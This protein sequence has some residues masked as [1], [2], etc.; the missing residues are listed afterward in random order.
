MQLDFQNTATAFAHRSDA[1]LQRALWMF[2]LIA[3]PA[4]VNAGEKLV[5]FGLRM[6]LPLKP[7]V[8]ATL[9]RQFAGGETVEECIPRIEELWRHKVATILDY[10]VE[11]QSTRADFDTTVQEIRKTIDLAHRHPAIPFSVFKMSGLT[12]PHVLERQGSPAEFEALRQ[13]VLDI[14]QHAHN[15]QVPVFIDAEESWVQETIDGLAEEMMQRFNRERPLVFT[16]LQFY[17]KDRLKYL[18]QLIQKSYAGNFWLGIKLVRGAYLEKESARARQLH[19]PNPLQNSKEE[20]DA[21]FNHALDVCLQHLERIHICA[22]THNEESTL[23]LVQK[24]QQAGLAPD[25]PRIWFSQLLG[26]SD[27]ISFNLAAAGYNVAKYMPYAPVESLIPYLV[28]RARENTSVQ[29]Q[30]GRE[31]RLLRQELRRRRQVRR[32]PAN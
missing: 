7:L 14:C 25:D 23:Y 16:T 18:E 22:G 24:M 27:H 6:R 2:R 12:S 11:G 4:L 26:M 9:F 28:R 3:S 8:R 31:L 32:T 10:S 17:R 13:R 1:D 29:G 21:D 15:R 30:T 5:H 19:Y 20:T